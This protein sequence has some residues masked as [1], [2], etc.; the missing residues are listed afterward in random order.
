MAEAVLVTEYLT[1]SMIDA[2]NQLLQKLEGSGLVMDAAFWLYHSEAAEWRLTL[3]VPDVDTEGPKRVYTRI[4]EVLRAQNGGHP[5]LSPV[6]V[7]VLSPNATLV[8]VLASAT[9]LIALAG[10]RLSGNR[11][12]G[13]YVDDIYILR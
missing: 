13:V 9:S 10:K 4:L 1:T 6:N 7:T 12:N 8:R 2:G 5:G 11:L 3:A